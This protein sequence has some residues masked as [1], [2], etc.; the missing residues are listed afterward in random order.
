MSRFFALL[1]ITF[2]GA[3]SAFMPVQQSSY[4]R[5]NTVMNAEKNNAVA[6]G[7]FAAATAASFL[8]PELASAKIEYEGVPYLGGSEKVDVNNAN[9]RVYSKFPGLYPTIAGKIVSNGPYKNVG[10][11]YSLLTDAEKTVLKKYED[12]LLALEPAPEY[13]IDRINNGLYR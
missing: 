5:S 3:V 10:E 6:A 9:V 1:F 12:K 7:L 2:C 8:A 4:S 11:I 13:V